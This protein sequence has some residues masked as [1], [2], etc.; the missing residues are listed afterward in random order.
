[1]SLLV[2]APLQLEPLAG[3]LVAMVLAVVVAPLRVVVPLMPVRLAELAGAAIP[4][5]SPSSPNKWLR[6]AMPRAHGACS[7]PLLWDTVVAAGVGFWSTGLEVGMLRCSGLEVDRWRWYCSSSC[8]AGGR[9][10]GEG[11]GWGVGQGMGEGVGKRVGKG[12]GQGVVGKGVGRGVGE[13]V[14]EGVG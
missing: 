5:E 2:V 4:V 9:G 3:L 7:Q 11:A 8:A 6:A 1:M 13:G 10:V 12:F 14:G